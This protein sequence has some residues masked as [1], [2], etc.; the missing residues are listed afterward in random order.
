MASIILAAAGSA[1]GG[2]IGGTFL[3]VSAA[4]IGGAVGSLVGA[5]VDSWLVAS[6]AP[7]QKIAGQRLDTL[8]ITASTEGAAIPRI[9]GRMRVGGNIIWATDFREETETTRHG[10]GGKGGGG[11]GGTEVTEYFYFASL[12]IALCEGPITGIGRIWADGK[13]MS[14]DGV[15]MRVHFGGEDQEPDPFIA[16]KMGAAS[17]PA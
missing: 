16:A 6:M 4:T 5:A 12:A 2:S 9:Y 15:T 11:G 17:T 10:G 13:P 3:G 14:L 1:I 7:T 8:Q